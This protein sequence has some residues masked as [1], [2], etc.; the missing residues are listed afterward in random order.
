[1][2]SSEPHPLTITVTKSGLHTTELRNHH[3]FSLRPGLPELLRRSPLISPSL[4]PS[5]KAFSH[6]VSV[7]GYPL[8]PEAIVSWGLASYLICSVLLVSTSVAFTVEKSGI[9]GT[10]FWVF[11]TP[12]AE[13]EA[14]VP[15]FL[16]GPAGTVLCGVMVTRFYSYVESK[17]KLI[18]CIK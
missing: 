11:L 8:I 12:A 17:K 16:M 18:S 15:F 3:L 13:G 1:M 9:A 6:L 7:A 2:S 10:P 14:C 4:S 5:P